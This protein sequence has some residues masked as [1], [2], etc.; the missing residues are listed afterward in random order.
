MR[1]FTILS[2]CAAAVVG[3]AKTETKA[4][5]AAAP[6]P[7]PALSLADVAGKW[8]VRG[9]N[10]AKDST[11]VTY[12]LTATADTS[13]WTIT[14]PNRKQPVAARV[15]AVAG[16]SLVMEAGPYESVLRKGV[17]VTTHGVLR[18]QDGKLVGLTIAHYKTAKADSVRRIPMEG[19]RLP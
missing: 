11:L 18:L 12:Q 9:M 15:A 19:T 1:R 14:F 6:P 3:C 13:G 4:P 7:P 10:E 2:C 5:A 17:Q 8:T 16:D